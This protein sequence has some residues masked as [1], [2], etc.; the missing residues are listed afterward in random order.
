M[1][2]RWPPK[3]R[4]IQLK[5]GNFYFIQQRLTCTFAMIIILDKNIQN[6]NFVI[7]YVCEIWF[8][9]LREEHNILGCHIVVFWVMTLCSLVGGYQ[10]FK[11]TFCLHGT[12]LTTYRTTWC[13]NPEDHNLNLTTV[14][15]LNPIQSE[16]V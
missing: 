5:E 12:L 6:Y 16:D 8:L 11:G 3:I 13:H 15:T 1:N 14:R 7:S 2:L 10:H 9:A 4:N